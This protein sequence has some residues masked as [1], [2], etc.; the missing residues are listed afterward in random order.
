MRV[1]HIHAHFDDFEFCAAG[2]FALW[3][4][5]LGADFVGKI[6]VCTDGRSGH[7]FRSRAETSA[8][9]RREQQASAVI[10]G[11]QWSEL[12]RPDGQPF[13]E[14]R[15]LSTDL[16]AALW[17]A[18][19]EFEPD[20]L[21]CPPL[22]R[23]PLAGVHPD[24]ITVAD[25]VRRVAYM[26]NVPHAFL[27]EYHAPETGTPRWIK[28]PVILNTH[29]GYMSGANAHD[30]QVDV[31]EVFDLI[32]AESWCHQSQ[33]T[34][35]LPWVG[36]HRM[37]APTDLEAWKRILRQRFERKALELGLAPHSLVE[38]FTATAWGTIPTATDLLRDFPQA[39]GNGGESALV[40]RLTRWQT[41]EPG[42]H[43]GTPRRRSL[44][45]TLSKSAS[46]T[47]MSSSNQPPDH[48]EEETRDE[49]DF[50]LGEDYPWVRILYF[51]PWF[52]RFAF[53]LG[54]VAI[55][56]LLAC[57]KLWTS[58][59]PGVVPPVKVSLLDKWQASRALRLF[60][61]AAAH[62]HSEMA[63]RWLKRAHANDPGNPLPSQVCL[64]W[65]AHH[66]TSKPVVLRWLGD[67]AS[68]LEHLTLTNRDSIQRIAAAFAAVEDDSLTLETLYPINDLLDPPARGRLLRACLFLGRYDL[69]DDVV[70]AGTDS[71]SLE[72]QLARQIRNVGEKNHKISGLIVET[73]TTNKTKFPSPT[74]AARF[75]LS[76]A[77]AEADTAGCE[78]A[79]A[80]LKDQ[81]TLLVRDEARYWTFLANHGRRGDAQELGRKRLSTG[82]DSDE[83]ETLVRATASLGLYDDAL[84]YL[85]HELKLD[86]QNANLRFLQAGLLLSAGRW[87]DLTESAI[88][89]RNAVA[90]DLAR[91]LG[92]LLEATA[93]AE[94][95]RLAVAQRCLASVNP[96][97]LQPPRL[98]IECTRHLANHGLAKEALALLSALKES[99]ASEPEYWT[100]FQFAAFHD[101]NS[102][103]LLKAATEAY[104]RWPG[105]ETIAGAYAAALVLTR[106]DP[107]TALGIT[108]KL[109]KK[110]RE[111]KVLQLTQ[112]MGLVQTHKW[113]EAALALTRLE[114]DGEPSDDN[115]YKTLVKLTRFEYLAGS[116]ATARA[117][118]MAKEIKPADLPQAQ[119]AWF[120][121]ARR[122]SNL[123]GTAPSDPV[124]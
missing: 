46:L 92:Y 116:G 99:Y 36:R 19:R 118:E 45:G 6:I 93:S 23:D 61:D 34:E 40:A 124:K 122:K 82:C 21:I 81:H 39:T 59:M 53:L 72:V 66:P 107:E 86:R 9:R 35:W 49:D 84:D 101:N 115:E 2:T 41:G 54:L 100:A 55:A 29:D 98:V 50:F 17:H 112:A 121:E 90:N 7:H 51:A 105:D 44:L 57:P 62:D 78:E 102:E 95:N 16:L 8:I 76:A 94:Q 58:S 1:L 75:L 5:K 79:L 68:I 38:T 64:D 104:Q 70:A 48:L 108:R 77:L 67:E 3:G 113:S 32:A 15:T 110:K 89:L 14:A 97:G 85:E 20:Y 33:I 65:Y 24:H 91:S 27:D 13:A 43:T 4:K 119:R 109:T 42:E 87:T 26:I 28:T 88:K 117:A 73:V 103:I 111:S 10:G 22:P 123:P 52:R 11:Y 47:S 60:K 83:A 80:Q 12:V 56:A 18:I 74:I 63:I 71:S 25:A 96:R 106:K 114:D 120:N 30:L 69:F 31:S 37:D